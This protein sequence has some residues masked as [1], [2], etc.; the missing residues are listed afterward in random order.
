MNFY[1]HYVAEFNNATRHLTLVER[2]LYKDLIDR[3]Y[4]TEQP[5]TNDLERLLKLLIYSEYTL[6]ILT[7]ILNEYFIP[8]ENGWVNKRCEIEI[9]HFKAI[10][11]KRSEAGKASGKARAKSKI[12]DRLTSDEQVLNKRATIRVDKSRVNILLENDKNKKEQF[13][14]FWVAYDKKVGKVKALAEWDK[15]NISDDLLQTILKSISTYKQSQPDS[16]YRKDPE[17]W[18]K[19]KRWEDEV[20]SAS[21]LQMPRVAL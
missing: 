10:Q 3:Y 6:E 14:K 9:E 8:T 4:E 15:L 1:P 5:L 2:A 18:L 13:N 12:N 7:N 17:R 21:V 16:K 19:E 20:T 11:N